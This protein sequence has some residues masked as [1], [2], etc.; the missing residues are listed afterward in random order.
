MKLEPF[1]GE[2]AAFLGHS[3]ALA[4]GLFDASGQ[5]LYLNSGMRFLLGIEEGEAPVTERFVLPTFDTLCDGATTP[6]V[7]YQGWLTFGGESIQY[8]SVRGEVRGDGETFLVIAEH[9]VEELERTNREI[10]Q[11]NSEITNLQRELV[12]RNAQIQET[13]DELR[14]TQAMLIHSEKMNALGQLVAGVA[15]EINNPLS[16]INS[17]LYSLR[18]SMQDIVE[19]YTALEALIQEQGTPA[20]HTAAQSIRQQADLDF[21][22]ED[23]GDL[24]EGSINGLNRIKK[25]VE[26]LRA[27]SRLDEAEFKAVDLLDGIKSALAIVQPQF[28]SRIDVTLD[29][30][31]LPPVHCYPSELNQVFLNLMVNAA[32]A[33]EGA[34]TL[35]IRGREQPEHI[36]LE[37]IDSGKGIAPDIRDRIFEPFF[38]TKPVGQGTGLGLSLAH[39][40]VVEHHKGSITVDSVLGEGSTF[41][42][43][44]PKDL[45]HESD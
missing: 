28:R 6:G 4:I 29:F 1:L 16:F 2:I 19:A 30:A 12:L 22:L 45:K 7:S 43:L 41:T 9:N 23:L 39:N 3:S 10:T 34:G 42:I 26:D 17:N 11:L 15:H 13:L 38:T 25:I 14:A 32:Q 31:P 20:Q 24:L 44:L 33:I 8:R 18:L 21:T 40:V 37:F 27:F 5:H 36:V 35:T